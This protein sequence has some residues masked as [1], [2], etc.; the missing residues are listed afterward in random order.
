MFLALTPPGAFL[1]GRIDPE[2]L[3]AVTSST[4][5]YTP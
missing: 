5:T 2:D 4:F 1:D 3:L